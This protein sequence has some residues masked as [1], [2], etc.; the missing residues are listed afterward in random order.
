MLAH[1]PQLVIVVRN[2]AEHFGSSPNSRVNEVL[3][4][5]GSIPFLRQLF[6]TAGGMN[7]P[8]YKSVQ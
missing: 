7:W 8:P 5:K 2:K 6:I 4:V 1:Y 3:L